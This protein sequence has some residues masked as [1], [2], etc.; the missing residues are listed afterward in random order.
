M[1]WIKMKVKFWAKNGVLA[2]AGTLL[3]LVLVLIRMYKQEPA[4]PPDDQVVSWHDAQ[5]EA[6]IRKVLKKP[7]GAITAGEMRDIWILNA[8]ECGIKSVEDFSYLSGLS[9]LDVSNNEI[10]DISPLYKLNPFYMNLSNNQISSID[11]ISGISGLQGLD[12]RN[13]PVEDIRDLCYMDWLYELS[14]S[15]SSLKNEN[16]LRWLESIYNLELTEELEDETLL[17]E[18]DCLKRL[19]VSGESRELGIEMEENSRWHSLLNT[20]IVWGS[21]SGKLLEPGKGLLNSSRSLTDVTPV[22]AKWTLRNVILI[23]RYGKRVAERKPIENKAVKEFNQWSE[24]HPVL[25]GVALQGI[26]I[27]LGALCIYLQLRR[28]KK[29]SKMA[30]RIHFGPYLTR[31][32]LALTGKDSESYL[33]RFCRVKRGRPSLHFPALFFGSNWLAYR[34]MWKEALVMAVLCR[35]GKLFLQRAAVYNY[36]SIGGKEV[37]KAA[38]ILYSLIITAAYGFLADLYYWS[39]IRA[40]LNKQGCKYRLKS[41]ALEKAPDN[42]ESLCV[43]PVLAFFMVC[44][45][46]CLLW[47]FPWLEQWGGI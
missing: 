31:D 11:G 23:D 6:L 17:K 4:G 27:A 44:I 24:A 21:N 37:W 14:L 20:D 1:N 39:R 18:L 43:S 13:N 8:S 35:G 10:R 7:E 28:D 22:S 26:L 9:Y 40:R 38:F 12:I 16:P 46:G 45:N 30:E 5:A 25:L 47:I 3:L 34:L 36:F 2:L 42:E 33:Y 41:E 15:P 32:I 19:T 29:I